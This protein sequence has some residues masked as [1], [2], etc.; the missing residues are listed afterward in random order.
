[1]RSL[2][3]KSHSIGSKRA[4]IGRSQDIDF[5]I[6]NSIKKNLKTKKSQA[7]S[8]TNEINDFEN[9]KSFSN[10]SPNLPEMKKF[11]WLSYNLQN[12]V[13]EPLKLYSITRKNNSSIPE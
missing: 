4:V 3:C 10:Y 9:F 5:L 6:N 12:W 7:N 11:R 8:K 1:M 2:T 13:K